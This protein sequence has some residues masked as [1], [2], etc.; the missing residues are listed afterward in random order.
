MRFHLGKSTQRQQH[1]E[2]KGS[3]LNTTKQVLSR[4]LNKHFEKNKSLPKRSFS[5]GFLVY[6][7]FH[8]W[9]RALLP[10]WAIS[11]DKFCN[12]KF[13][14]AAIIV[15]ETDLAKHWSLCPS[16]IMYSTHRPHTTCNK[17]FVNKFSFTTLF[18]WMGIWHNTQTIITLHRKVTFEWNLI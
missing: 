5:L 4:G 3:S 10:C 11:S 17:L 7:T 14:L 16:L 13:S 15:H 6:R 8:S 2:T 1:I 9:S 12:I 18:T